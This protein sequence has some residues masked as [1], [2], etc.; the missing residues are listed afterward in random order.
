LIPA[1]QPEQRTPVSSTTISPFRPARPTPSSY[2][3]APQRPSLGI[4]LITFS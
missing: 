3:P 4:E 1:P 2:T